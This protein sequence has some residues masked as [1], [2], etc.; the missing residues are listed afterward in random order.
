MTVATQG[1][2]R[3]LP[4]A[5]L[6]ATIF[7]VSSLPSRELPTLGSWDALAKKGAHGLGYGLLAAA[8][9][10]GLGWDRK[11]WWLALV[12]AAAYACTDELHQRFTPGRHSSVVDVGIDSFGAAVAVALCALARRKNRTERIPS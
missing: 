3:W 5:I 8:V 1:V 11:L 9:W 7:F 6:A 2:L 4:V 10:R 12:V